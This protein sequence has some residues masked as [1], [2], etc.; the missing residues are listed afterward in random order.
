[1]HFPWQWIPFFRRTE[2]PIDWLLLYEL[3]QDCC[4]AYKQ[5]DPKQNPQELQEEEWEIISHLERRLGTDTDS[6]V[7]FS[8]LPKSG[9][10][11]LFTVDPAGKQHIAVCGTDSVRSFLVDLKYLYTSDISLGIRIHAGFLDAALELYE[12]M[13]PFLSL[14]HPV[15]FTG[16]SLGGA[17]A[18]ICALMLAKDGCRI[19]SVVTFGQPKFTDSAGAALLRAQLPIPLLRVAAFD[20]VVPALPPHIP[21]VAD[22]VHVGSCLV[23]L[24]G[25]T[26]AYLPDGASSASQDLSLWQSWRSGHAS[27][28]AH[29]VLHYAHLLHVNVATPPS[30]TPL[31]PTPPPPPTE[32]D[33]KHGPPP[34]RFW[35]PWR[36]AH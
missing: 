27:I 4:L 33:A 21:E 25:N 30:R 1:M 12:D 29:R 36:A 28:D 17:M 34:R 22:Y 18:A 9:T 19:D 11:Y 23:L 8:S 26:Y 3:M 6:R 16:H 32:E 20:D 15:S 24:Q 2:S 10:R 14:N 5:D 7:I 35:L 31:D 13:K